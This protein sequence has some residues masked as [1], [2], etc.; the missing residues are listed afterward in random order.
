MDEE[1]VIR[2]KRPGKTLLGYW[3][4]LYVPVPVAMKADVQ[5]ICRE[6]EMSQ[7]EFGLR[8]MQFVFNH[9]YLL[10]GVRREH[11]AAAPERSDAAGGG[12]LN[13]VG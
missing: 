10:E 12:L 7:A 2:P 1:Y 5:R 13:V 4:K 3:L 9:D 8:V 11:L 6:W